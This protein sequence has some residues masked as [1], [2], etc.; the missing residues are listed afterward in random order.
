[1]SRKVLGLDI[2]KDAVSAVVVKTSLRENRIDAHAY[3]PLPDPTE[4]ADNFR[5]ALHALWS[6]LE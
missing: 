3:I 6:T 5:T 4:D 2:R 1:M